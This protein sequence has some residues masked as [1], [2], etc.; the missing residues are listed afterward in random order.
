[1]GLVLAVSRWRAPTTAISEASGVAHSTTCRLLWEL[2]RDG[3]LE[4]AFSSGAYVDGDVWPYRYGP[5]R[6]AYWML[7]PAGAS[8]AGELARLRVAPH[9]PPRLEAA[10][11][12]RPWLA[13]REAERVARERVA[14]EAERRVREVREKQARGEELT[15]EEL[16]PRRV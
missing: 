8:R 14:A 13:V 10:E 11:A 2:K 6:E 4:G 15:P 7:A 3:F 5:L 9:A 1:M 12:E 16:R